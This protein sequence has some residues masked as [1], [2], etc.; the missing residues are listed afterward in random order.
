MNF[1]KMKGIRTQIDNP[2][3]YSEQNKI[4]LGPVENLTIRAPYKKHAKR[5]NDCDMGDIGHP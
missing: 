5:V 1:N 3:I 4:K 2:N